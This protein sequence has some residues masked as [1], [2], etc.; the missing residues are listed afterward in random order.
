M[1]TFIEPITTQLL[2]PTYCS[3]T[4]ACTSKI[5]TVTVQPNFM[6]GCVTNKDG[7]AFTAM[8]VV[9]YHEVIIMDGHVL[10]DLRTHMKKVMTQ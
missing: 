7:I 3:T 9:I 2:K 6:E 1:H 8:Y 5:Y 10:T 4:V